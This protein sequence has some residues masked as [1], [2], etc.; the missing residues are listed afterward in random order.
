M[1]CSVN[2]VQLS[3]ARLACS[4]CQAWT[5]R[6]GSSVS[7]FLAL[8][9]HFPTVL[10]LS[11]SGE[12]IPC[13]IDGRQLHEVKAH[14]EEKCSRI[15]EEHEVHSL[16]LRSL[17]WWTAA[18]RILSTWRIV[19]RGISA[20]KMGDVVVP[21]LT[22]LSEMLPNISQ[23]CKTN[24][25]MNHSQIRFQGPR[26]FLDVFV[27]FC[28][29]SIGRP[30]K[31]SLASGL[32]IG[33]SVSTSAW[34]VDTLVYVRFMETTSKIA[35]PSFVLNFALMLRSSTPDS[36]C[37]SSCLSNVSNHDHVY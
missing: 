14:L 31:F 20:G 11:N 33:S 5:C 4:G 37:G 19:A 28:R 35:S 10:M 32:V 25:I 16:K 34:H 15:C 8:L 23:D 2:A 13:S 24:T 17:H 22:D 3:F 27:V 36:C 7:G 29:W 30:P 18:L 9:S 26:V 1:S 12:H 6:A 21:K